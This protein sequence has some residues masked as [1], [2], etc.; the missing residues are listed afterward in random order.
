M[1]RHDY[2]GSVRRAAFQHDLEYVIHFLVHG[3]DAVGKEFIGDM[4]G[5]LIVHIF[6]KHMAALIHGSK[7]HEQQSVFKIPQQ[8][9]ES[10]DPFFIHQHGLVPKF[11]PAEDPILEGFGVLREFLRGEIP[12]AFTQLPAPFPGMRDGHGGIL[13]ID[14]QRGNV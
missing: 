14:L 12:G 3:P 8:T 5:M 7:I 4:R 2:D 6:P 1:V 13:G 9:P 11:P 10:L